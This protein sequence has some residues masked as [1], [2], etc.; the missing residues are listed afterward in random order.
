[1]AFGFIRNFGASI[2]TAAAMVLV[3]PGLAPPASAQTQE[4]FRRMMEE[5]AKRTNRD[6]ERAEENQGQIDAPSWN[7]KGLPPVEMFIARPALSEVVMSPDGKYIAA[8]RRDAGTTFLLLLSLDGGGSKALP[9]PGMRIAD[10]A[11]G[12][13]DRLIYIAG[14][15][16]PTLQGTDRGIVMIGAPRLYS[17]G[18]DLKNPV[19]FFEKDKRLSRE[20]FGAEILPTRIEGDTR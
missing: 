5:T 14:S 17:I 9:F 4:E 12:S 10:V 2:C 11:W 15:E 6:N 13:N 1:M 8:V 3:S 18:L 20:N 7:A 16:N 19:M